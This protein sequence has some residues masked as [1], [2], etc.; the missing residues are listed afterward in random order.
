[1]AESLRELERRGLLLKRKVRSLGRPPSAEEEREIRKEARAIREGLADSMMQQLIHDRPEV[2]SRGKPHS[3]EAAQ[4]GQNEARSRL[5]DKPEFKDA[6]SR[7][8]AAAVTQRVD[9]EVSVVCGVEGTVLSSAT[10]PQ[11]VLTF[12]MGDHLGCPSW[13][14]EKEA[15]AAGRKAALV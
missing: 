7:C 12:C 1:M 9:G 11:S 14:A 13:Q 10:D 3:G 2:I 5:H 6:C 4:R 8:P 15:I